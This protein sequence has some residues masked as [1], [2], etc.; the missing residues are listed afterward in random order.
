MIDLQIKESIPGKSKA[1]LI[2]S[3]LRSI[4][5]HDVQLFYDKGIVPNGLWA[6]VQIQRKT[7]SLIMPASYHEHNVQPTIMWWC[8]TNEGHFRVPND[9]DLHDI[10]VTVQRAQT[11]FLKGGDWLN[12]RFDEQSAEKDRRHR[13]K[14][15]DMV[16]SIAKP[17]KK[18]IKEE[19]W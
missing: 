18:A 5:I 3:K 11:S 7:T 13:Q 6:V 2:M 4:G 14:Q 10:I 17:L 12:D 15:R 1:D 16:H 9:Q 19:R 8:K